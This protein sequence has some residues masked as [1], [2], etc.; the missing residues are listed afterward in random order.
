MRNGT[1][2][3]VVCPLRFSQSTITGQQ[4]RRWRT[5]LSGVL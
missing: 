5:V 2:F 4:S 3:S 1:R